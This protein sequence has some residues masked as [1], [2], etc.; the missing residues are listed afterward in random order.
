MGAETPY[1]RI[2]IAQAYGQY[3]YILLPA[4]IEA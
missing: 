3:V 4:L 2:L 1:S